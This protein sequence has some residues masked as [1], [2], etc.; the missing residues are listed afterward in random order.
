[1]GAITAGN[2]VCIKPSE[3]SE[4]T[5]VILAKLI[6][7]YLDQKAFKARPL[8]F[9]YCCLPPATFLVVVFINP[10]HA[11]D[12]QVVNGA[13]AETTAVLAERWDKIL[14]TGNGVVGRVVLNA[15][16]KYLTPVI[17]E[18]GGKR[19]VPC[20][21]LRCLCLAIDCTD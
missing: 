20:F 8:P 2:C 16:A 18:L 17:L 14:Y 6:P 5:A 9:C 3:L 11:F 15:A 13:V 4:H 1:V 21:V 10:S 19:Y 7:Q 12:L